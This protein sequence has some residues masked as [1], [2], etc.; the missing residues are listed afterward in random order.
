MLFWESYD[1]WSV[2]GFLVGIIGI[3]LAIFIYFRGKSKKILKYHISS[4]VLLS[5]NMA[6][7]M[8][9]VPNLKVTISDEPITD[10]TATNIRFIN[11][12]NQS[13]I[14]KDFPPKAPLTI[15]TDGK[16]FA[17]RYAVGDEYTN[18]RTTFYEQVLSISFDCLDVKHGFT[19]TLWHTGIINISG[20]LIDGKILPY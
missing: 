18:L 2:G 17:M 19:I 16:F 3:L 8:A 12:G 9:D 20:K 14:P 15:T 1:I 7:N 13:L 6:Y 11:R 10:L 5:S 4:T